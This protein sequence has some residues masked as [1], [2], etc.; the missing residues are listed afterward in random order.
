MTRVKIEQVI[1]HLSSGMRKAL[2]DAVAQV[3]PGKDFD[4][5]ELF[6]AFR[7]AVGRKCSA[8]ERVPSH[9]VKVD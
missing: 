1:D 7:R 9:Y 8:W 3:I 5:R 2:A 4:D 6:R